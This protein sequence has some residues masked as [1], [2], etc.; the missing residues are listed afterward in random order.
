MPPRASCALPRRRCTATLRSSAATGGCRTRILT[1]PWRS[2]AAHPRQAPLPSSAHARRH[3]H[4]ARHGHGRAPAAH[5]FQAH[6]VVGQLPSS[7]KANLKRCSDL[8]LEVSISEL[9]VRIPL[10]AS[11]AELAQQ[12]T[13]YKTATENC[14]GVPRCAGVTVWGITDEY[15]WVPGTFSGYGAALP[16]SETYGAKPAYQGLSDGLDP[17]A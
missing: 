14:L 9:D 15:S 17:Q 3:G 5:G 7:M 6:F 10:P 1:S 8:G 2:H 16:Y 11:S 13:D 4:P 12:S